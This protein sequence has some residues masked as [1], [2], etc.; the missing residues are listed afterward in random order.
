M[1]EQRANTVRTPYEHRTRTRTRTTE[2]ARLDGAG[3][4]APE[5]APKASAFYNRDITALNLVPWH[6]GR[7]IYNLIVMVV[8]SLTIISRI[9]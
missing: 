6:Q 4:G 5:I 9:F 7:N 8:H 3:G 1:S 2:R